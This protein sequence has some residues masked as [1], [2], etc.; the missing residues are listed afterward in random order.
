LNSAPHGGGGIAKEGRVC[1]FSFICDVWPAR[2]VFIA[3]QTQQ[4]RGFTELQFFF[5]LDSATHPDCPTSPP[6]WNTPL[7]AYVVTLCFPRFLYVFFPPCTFDRITSAT[8][9]AEPYGSWRTTPI[10]SPPPNPPPGARRTSRDPSWTPI[11]M[12]GLGVRMCVPTLGR[13]DTSSTL[14]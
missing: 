13:P 6:K 11:H 8:T 2:G 3:G 1:H 10:S 9:S 7:S 4:A 12:P 5:V 14:H